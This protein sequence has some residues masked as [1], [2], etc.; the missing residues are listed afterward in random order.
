MPDVPPV[1]VIATE[2]ENELSLEVNVESSKFLSQPFQ[3]Q[4]QVSNIDAD[5]NI[6]VGT[7][8]GQLPSPIAPQGASPQYA[9]YTL[10]KVFNRYAGYISL[11]FAKPKTDEEKYTPYETGWTFG[12]FYWHPI[13]DAL[14]FIEDRNFPRFTSGGKYGQNA[15]ISGPTY[16]V[17]EGYRPSLNEGTRFYKKEY[18]ANTP[19]IIPSF[20]VPHPSSVSYDMNGIRGQFPECLHPEINIPST[21]TANAAFIVGDY[22]VASGALS[23]QFFPATNFEEREPY[24]F[25]ADTKPQNGGFY[26]ATIT[27][28][29]PIT[30]DE[31][32]FK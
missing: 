2:I 30:D 19:Y 4:L 15:I 26:M 1:S 27:A 28:L 16:Y 25:S 22:A 20:M 12:N 32:T 10:S 5:G 17:R 7:K 23:G 29:P 14:V 3:D 13:L 9:N 24:T 11:S 31:E 6:I 18:F 21:Q 8:Y